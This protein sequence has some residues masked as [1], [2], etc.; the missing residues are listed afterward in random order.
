[1][2]D[3]TLACG[4]GATA[5]AIAAF[6]AGLIKE[7][8]VKLVALGGNLEVRFNKV[9]NTYTDIRLIGA[10]KFVFKGEINV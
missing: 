9:E 3:E 6:E 4:T 8:S 7:N 10:A 1:M 5:T 2:E